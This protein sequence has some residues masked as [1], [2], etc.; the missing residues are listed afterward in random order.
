M[1]YIKVD[2]S[3]D[4]VE[5]R[6]KTGPIVV[7]PNPQE[8]ALYNWSDT[9]CETPVTNRSLTRPGEY[10]IVLHIFSKQLK[11]DDDDLFAT[12]EFGVILANTSIVS[13]LK[14]VEN[15]Q[16]KKRSVWSDY[17]QWCQCDQHVFIDGSIPVPIEF[18]MN[19]L[20]HDVLEC[21]CFVEY[22][23]LS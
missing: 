20:N 17:P 9:K 11:M 2:V 12:T 5:G 23:Y 1:A 13:G 14:W 6:Y 7:T 15:D 18:N 8:F 21:Q 4:R 16:N 22:H 19:T 10:K 3:D